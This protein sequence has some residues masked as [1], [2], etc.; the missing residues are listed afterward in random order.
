MFAIYLDSEKVV[1][2][3]TRLSR[4]EPRNNA[5]SFELITAKWPLY[6]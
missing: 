5:S 3:T 4:A 2:L 1:V 6:L